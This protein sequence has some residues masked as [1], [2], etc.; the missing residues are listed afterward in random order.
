MHALVGQGAE[1]RAQGG[2][3]P[4]GKVDIAALRG[5]EMLLHGDDLLLAD[6]AVP[7]AEALGLEG[8]VRVVGGHV[9]AH[10]GGGVAGDVQ[11][12]LEAVL[13]THA[14]HSV[15]RDGIPRAGYGGDEIGEVGGFG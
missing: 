10:H 3:H 4:A 8:R 1:I 9:G 14:R 7:G 6:E 13:Q 15:R 11:P 5:A 2:D 12:G